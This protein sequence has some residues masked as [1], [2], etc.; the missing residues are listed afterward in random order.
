MKISATRGRTII[1]QVSADR[2]CPQDEH[3]IS[4]FWIPELTD[5]EIRKHCKNV[6]PFTSSIQKRKSLIKLSN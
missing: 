4:T 5:P 1:I 6:L 2:S 3:L